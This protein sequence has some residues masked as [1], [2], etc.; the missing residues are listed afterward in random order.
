MPDRTDAYEPTTRRSFISA[1]TAGAGVVA[2]G[3][4]GWGLLGS[5][6]PSA[7]MVAEKAGFE[8]KLSSI[9]EGDQLT[10]NHLGRLIIVRHRTAY[11]IAEAE[12]VNLDDL[13]DNTTRDLF[14]R[15]LGDADDRNRRATPDGKF[16]AISG[17]EPYK[18]CV[19]LQGGDWTWFDPCVSTHFDISGRARRYGFSGNLL[20]PVSQYVAPDVLRV[21]TDPNHLKESSLDDLLY[22]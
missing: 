1:A 5:M 6:A 2:L 13:T 19:V 14:G 22:R 7:D 16:I 8:I 15:Y 21:F 20:L 10:I 4:A 12:A 11:E 9:P 3:A 17:T 18:G